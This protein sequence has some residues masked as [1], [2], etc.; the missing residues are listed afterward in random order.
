MNRQGGFQMAREMVEQIQQ[1]EQQAEQTIRD[2][3]AQAEMLRQRAEQQGRQLCRQAEQ[4]AQQQAQTILTT[5]QHT[6]YKITN[7]ASAEH[8]KKAQALE[9]AAVMKGMMARGKIADER[10]YDRMYAF[11]SSGA[12]GVFAKAWRCRIEKTAY[13]GTVYV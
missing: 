5:A 13:G 2:A 1:A 3:R 6:A 4:Q 7:R 11:G 12:D 10:H 8:L 9:Q